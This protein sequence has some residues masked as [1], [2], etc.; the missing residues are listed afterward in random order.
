MLKQKRALDWA[1]PCTTAELQSLLPIVL[2][3]IAGNLESDLQPKLSRFLRVGAL[4]NPAAGGVAPDAPDRLRA[5]LEALGVDAPEII[6]CEAAEMEASLKDLFSRTLDVVVVLGGDGTAQMAAAI[7][8]AAAGPPLLVLPGGTM[9]LLPHALHGPVDWETA[10]RNALMHGRE[11]TIVGGVVNG[12]AF[13]VAAVFGSP[14]FYALGREAVRSG[15]LLTAWRRLRY[16]LSRSFQRRLLVRADQNRW[17]RVEALGV[18]CPAFEKQ[19]EGPPGLEWATFDARSGFD[20]LRLGMSAVFTDWRN[21]PGITTRRCISAVVRARAA[22]PGLLDGEPRYFKSPVRIELR[23][24]AARVIA[25]D[26]T[27]R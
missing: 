16:A 11:R 3:M 17:E 8:G 23:A 13:F 10:L 20:L 25:P 12:E 27:S 6:A 24:R 5:A 1:V 18:L 4:V 2:S 22:I 14:A 19:L 9:N 26:T 21:D 15:R 7:A